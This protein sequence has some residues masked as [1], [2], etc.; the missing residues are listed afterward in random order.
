MV[1]RIT[2]RQ[3]GGSVSVTIPKDLAERYHMSVGEPGFAI[4]TDQG[5]LLTSYDPDFDRA[6]QVYARVAK[7]YRNA[8]RELARK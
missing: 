4:E 2:M 6:M 7:R 5:L 3:A 8:L 1:R